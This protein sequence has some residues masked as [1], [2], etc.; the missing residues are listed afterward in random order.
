MLNFCVRV[1]NLI[2][3]LH[4]KQLGLGLRLILIATT[5]NRVAWS[6]RKSTFAFRYPILKSVMLLGN[7]TS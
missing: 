4:L 3:D 1:F 2:K 6:Y 7:R 5:E